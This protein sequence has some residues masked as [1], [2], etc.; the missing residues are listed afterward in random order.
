MEAYE[1]REQAL[2]APDGVRSV[3]WK[4]GPAE[5]TPPPKPS[6]TQP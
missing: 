1:T 3:L 4:N 2:G 5:K 6:C